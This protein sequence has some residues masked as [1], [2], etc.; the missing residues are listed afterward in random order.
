M[1]TKFITQ[2]AVIAAVYIA[3]TA[4]FAPI[5]FG[6]NFFQLRVSEALTVLPIFT[7]A[8]VPGLFIGCAVSNIA[9]G[10]LGII[11]LIFGSLATLISS[12]LSYLLR[13]KSPLIALAS[14]VCVNAVVVGTYL[15]L[16][17]SPEINPLIN[18]AWVFVGQLLSCYGLGLP[19]YKAIDKYG[20][21]FFDAARK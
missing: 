12:F 6:H 16:L 9:F 21:R 4:I 20:K 15:N 8:A 7:P 19:L 14:P 17:I 18:I 3:A 1:K 13:R 2:S 10:G 11:D 5:S